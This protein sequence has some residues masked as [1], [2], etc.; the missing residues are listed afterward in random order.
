M[1]GLLPLPVD[2]VKVVI[3]DIFLRMAVILAARALQAAA[4]ELWAQLNAVYVLLAR[5]H[6]LEVPCVTR[7]QKAPSQ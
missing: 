3:Q 4:R 2:N 7:A 1:L 6:H 5:T